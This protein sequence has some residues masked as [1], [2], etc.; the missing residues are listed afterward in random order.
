MKK[1]VS[2]PPIKT[3][4]DTLTEC[5]VRFIPGEHRYIY[6]DIFGSKELSGI[7]SMLSRQL[8]GSKYAGIDEAVLQAAAERGS[9]VHELCQWEDVSGLPA[10][11]V[12]DEYAKAAH[13]YTEA[14]SSHGYTPMAN[15]YIVSDLDHV[16]SAIDCV[17][18][19]G[20]EI[21]LADIKT[22]SKLDRLYLSW[23]LSVYAY[24]F[25]LQ[26]FGAEVDMLVAVWLPFEKGESKGCELVR[27]ER[28]PDEH[29]RAL[30]A[31]DKEGRQYEPPQEWA[32][33]Q[34]LT[35]QS[36]V[37]ALLPSSA[38][39]H[40]RTACQMLKEAQ[41]VKGDFEEALLKAMEEHNIKTWDVETMRFTRT[42]P[43]ESVGFDV[44]AFQAENPELYQKYMT[45]V[46]K[47]AASLRVTIREH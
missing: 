36:D 22:T 25:E 6:N 8:F 20:D 10:E 16:A 43:T 40:Y 12:N 37:P 47:R 21:V 45:K 26:N 34:V 27:I 9:A 32:P 4:I 41:I 39:V 23:Q 31:A 13:A 42:E 46:T 7:T 28:I 17:W 14:R 30:I 19:K 18:R 2:L 44:K 1:K 35:T 38:I 15:E 3:K 33:L 24:L 29:V 11:H 5:P